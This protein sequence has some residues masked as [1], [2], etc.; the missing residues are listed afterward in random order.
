MFY[1]TVAFIITASNP[2]A[3]A[4]A[5][6]ICYFCFLNYKTTQKCELKLNLKQNYRNTQ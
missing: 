3:L 1:N 4:V 5:E 2:P 6:N